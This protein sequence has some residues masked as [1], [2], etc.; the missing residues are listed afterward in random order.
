MVMDQSQSLKQ[1]HGASF[2]GVKLDKTKAEPLR[3]RLELSDAEVAR[4]FRD[5]WRVTTDDNRLTL[6]SFRRFRTA[7]LLNLR[8][9]E[10]EIDQIDHIIYQAG[11]KLDVPLAKED[12]L[13]LRHGKKD[14]NALGAEETIDRE[15][16]LHLRHLLKEYGN[17]YFPHT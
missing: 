11:L 2:D 8:F 16:V 1:S 14:V 3:T 9:L 5:L 7:H 4:L 15:S 12:R 10:A 6:F 17:A 13:G